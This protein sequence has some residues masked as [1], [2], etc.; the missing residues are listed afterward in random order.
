[1][2]TNPENTHKYVDR[3]LLLQNSLSRGSL[4]LESNNVAIVSIETRWHRPVLWGEQ[5]HSLKRRAETGESSFF[6]VMPTALLAHPQEHLRGEKK[7]R[8]C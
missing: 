7:R 4:D 1:M 2:P 8:S 6:V 3:P 5:T